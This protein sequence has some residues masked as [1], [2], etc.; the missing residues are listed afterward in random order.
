[1]SDT[2]T[3]KTRGFGVPDVVDPHHFVV[4][5]PKGSSGDILIIGN[6]SGGWHQR[7]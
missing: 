5:I 2:K 3:R 6:C 1:M 4:R 7:V